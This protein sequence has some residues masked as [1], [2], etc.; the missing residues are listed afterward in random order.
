MNKKTVVYMGTTYSFAKC[1]SGDCKGCDRENYAS[2][3]VIF[4]LA[5][6][7]EEATAS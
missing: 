2:C 6:E 1:L 4:E 3:N 7:A 5:N